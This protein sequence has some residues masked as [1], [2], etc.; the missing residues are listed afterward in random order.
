MTKR[1]GL[2][3]A[4][5]VGTVI[6]LSM[7]IPLGWKLPDTIANLLGG[8]V[9]AAAS[10]AGAML[11]VNRQI[12]E[13]DERRAADDDRERQKEAGKLDQLQRALSNALHNDLRAVD[14]ML[15]GQI[16]LSRGMVFNGQQLVTE[17]DFADWCRRL[18]LL[19]MTSFH[20]FSHLLHHMDSISTLLIH[21]YAETE[22]I[23]SVCIGQRT[24][25]SSDRDCIEF[26]EM[27]K[28]ILPAIQHNV[29]RAMEVLEPL[30][31]F[32]SEEELIAAGIQ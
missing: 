2:V 16:L 4:G 13:E 20:R 18:E 15:T 11:V 5:A 29:R 30:T 9:G 6:G 8:V 28:G 17:K 19:P 7:S 21:A 25:R 26:V 22:R 31:S 23:R 1:A 3:L 27:A 24:Q 12:A 14:V 32:A 10:V